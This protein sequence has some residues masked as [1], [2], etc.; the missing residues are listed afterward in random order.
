MFESI[1]QGQMTMEYIA[2][3]ELCVSQLYQLKSSQTTFSNCIGDLHSKRLQ[4]GDHDCPF[5]GKGK[6][7]EG[8]MEFR[9]I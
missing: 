4:Y 9:S 7:L 3:S 1:K 8:I 2:G 6:I 5:Q